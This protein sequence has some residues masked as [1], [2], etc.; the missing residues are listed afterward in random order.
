M[1][2]NFLLYANFIAL[3]F[4][5]PHLLP[6]EVLHCGVISRFMAKNSGNIKIFVRTPKRECR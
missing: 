4:I 2:V 5:E 1:A 6:I 3:S